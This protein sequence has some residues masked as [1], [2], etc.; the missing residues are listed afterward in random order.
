LKVPE[1]AKRLRQISADLKALARELER[2]S[3]ESASTQPSIRQRI[4]RNIR[5]IGA[6]LNMILEGD[7]MSLRQALPDGLRQQFMSPDHDHRPGRFAVMLH[8]RENVW[9][10]KAMGRFIADMRAVEPH[11]TGTPITQYESLRDMRQ[12][13]GLMSMLAVLVIAAIVTMDFRNLRDILLVLLPMGVGALW[14]AEAMG[15][16]GISFN[17]ANF[18]SVPIL[19]GL[20][21]NGSV[22]VLQRYRE[23]GPTRFTLGATRRAVILTALNTIIGFG[24]LSFA[25]HH[26]LRS[27]GLVMTI[28]MIACLIATVIILPAMLKWL[29]ERRDQKPAT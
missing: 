2:T 15:L 7:L 12:S 4:E 8:P 6:S 10:F 23:G 27:L 3:G 28:G 9:E 5:A 25:R 19:I 18:F 26:G 22:Y 1:E 13:F 17:L 24:C 20:S 11:V 29:E 16:L 14:T 21:V